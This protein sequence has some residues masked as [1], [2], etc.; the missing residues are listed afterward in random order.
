MVWLEVY[1][2]CGADSAGTFNTIIIYWVSLTLARILVRFLLTWPFPVELESR[3]KA[4]APCLAIMLRRLTRRTASSSSCFPTGTCNQAGP[5]FG[6]F[7]DNPQGKCCNNCTKQCVRS[8]SQSRQKRIL[9]SLHVLSA[10]LYHL[11]ELSRLCAIL[12][13]SSSWTHLYGNYGRYIVCLRTFIKPFPD[14]Y[15]AHCF[16]V[17]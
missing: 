15:Y 4:A 17:C 13:S 2:F 16:L 1:G 8:L 7:R 14:N 10:R 9:I 11:T 6:F 5:K 12:A 3:G